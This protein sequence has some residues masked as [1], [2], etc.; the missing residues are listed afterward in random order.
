M[1]SDNLTFENAIDE[2]LLSKSQQKGVTISEDDFKCIL[3]ILIILSKRGAFQ[4]EEYKVVGD[5]FDRLKMVS[6]S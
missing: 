4:L 6:N 3:N 2:S 5:L 1:E